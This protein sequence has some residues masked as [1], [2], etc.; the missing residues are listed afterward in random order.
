VSWSRIKGQN[1]AVRLLR[2][3]VKADKVA[4]AYLFVGPPGV[5]KGL[6]A[7]ELAKSLNCLSPDP[8]GGACDVCLSC[9]K[10]EADPP[11]HPDLVIVVP[12]G[13]FIKTEQMK[14]LQGEMYARPVE[15]RARIAIVDG[16]ER[17]NQ[18]SGNR[19]LK[20]L[21]EPPSYAVLILLTTNLAGVLPTIQS[22]CQVVNFPPLTSAEV[23]A[24]LQE[25]R[26]MAPGEASL[27]AALSGGSIGRAVEMASH[28]EILAWR[29]EALEWLQRLREMDDF[30]LLSA[31]EALDKQRESLDARL[32][33]LTLWLRD[34]LLLAQGAPEELVVNAD[35]LGEGRRLAAAYGAAGLAA[36]LES[37]A[38]LRSAILRNANTRL[39][40][41]VMML[42]L[43]RAALS[44][45]AG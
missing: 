16:A 35:K 30:D 45:A 31:A 20:L 8:E 44:T 23:A 42:R 34:G 29:D 12:D 2:Q 7:L 43:Q 41:D 11:V 36:M 37:V 18:E 9:R 15:G 5:G 14:A 19:V 28:P 4:H 33:M 17:L 21:E 39:A 1:L 38:D 24:Y 32:D 22:R 13:R 27:F 40:L 6:A 3:A 10:M 26:S 25:N